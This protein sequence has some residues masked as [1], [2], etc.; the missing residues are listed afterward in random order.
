MTPA[1][2][3]REPQFWVLES[4]LGTFFI[5]LACLS[6]LKIRFDAL[7]CSGGFRLELSVSELARIYFSQ[8]NFVDGEEKESAALQHALEVLGSRCEKSS[9]RTEISEGKLRFSAVQKI[10]IYN[11]ILELALE[12]MSHEAFVAVFEREVL[13]QILRRATG[14]S[15]QKSLKSSFN[16]KMPI[17]EVYAR[18]NKDSKEINEAL[19]PEIEKIIQAKRG[20][21]AEESQVREKQCPKA[22]T[23]KETFL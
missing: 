13:P 8:N 15:L 17:E 23:K 22:K 5:R 18:F 11:L 16:S 6:K 10:D 12:P 20:R 14:V 19:K 2:G 7:S 1:S 3:V 4:E 21:L 9:Y